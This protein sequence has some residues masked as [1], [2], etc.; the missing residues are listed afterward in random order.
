[1]KNWVKMKYPFWDRAKLPLTIFAE[2]T[3][4]TQ[5]STNNTH[6]YENMFLLQLEILSNSN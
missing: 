1:M 4:I 6:V 5:Q 3:L 2:I